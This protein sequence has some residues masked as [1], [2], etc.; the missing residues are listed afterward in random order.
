MGMKVIA[1]RAG[2]GKTEALLK[3]AKKRIE[4]GLKTVLIVPEQYSFQA[5]RDLI[6]RLEKPGILGT[7]VLSFSRLVYRV[8]ELEGGLG[9]SH[10][11]DLGKTMLLRK[12]FEENGDD[13]GVFKGAFKK[14]G[15]ITRLNRFLNELKKNGIVPEELLLAASEIKGLELL[16]EKLRDIA[17]AYEYMENSLE[18]KYTDTWNLYALAEEKLKN[19]DIYRETVFYVD[20]FAG[21]TGREKGLIKALLSKSENVV[22]TLTCSMDENGDSYVFSNTLR[23]LNELKALALEENAAFELSVFEPVKDLGELSFLRDHF[24]SYPTVVYKGKPGSVFLFA[25]KNRSSEIENAAGEILRLA[26]ENGC[27]YRDMVILCDMAIYGDEIRRV[28]ADYGIPCF[29]DQKRAI[30]GSAMARYLLSALET[31]E[32]NMRYEDVFAYLKTGLAD[33]DIETVEKL[34]NHVLARGIRGSLWK[35]PLDVENIEDGELLEAA[36]IKLWSRFDIFRSHISNAKN[37]RGYVESIYRFLD[38]GEAAKKMEEFVDKLTSVGDYEYASEYSQIWNILM[39]IFDQLIEVGGDEKVDLKTFIEILKSGIESY[40]V[41]IIPSTIDQVLV[42]GLKRTRFHRV[43]ALFMIGINDRVIPSVVEDSGIMLDE[44]IRIMQQKGLPVTMDGDT[45]V[46]EER[47]AIYNA[48]ARPTDFIWFSYALSDAEGQNLRPSIL[49]GRLKQLFPEMDEM[50]DNL[51]SRPERVFRAPKAAYGHV[52]EALRRYI[53]EHREMTDIEK[54]LACWISRSPALKADFETTRKA[55]F[56]DNMDWNITS[57]VASELYGAPLRSSSSRIERYYQCPFQHFVT[58]GLRPF[59]RKV[60]ELKSP[61]VGR[62]FHESVESFA[63]KIEDRGLDWR[64]LSKDKVDGIMSEAAKEIMEGFDGKILGSTER[65]KYFADRI[66]RVA[67]KTANMAVE[68]V[69]RGGFTPTA[70]EMAFG[71]GKPIPPIIIETGSGET[72][73]LEGRIDRIDIC[74]KD[75]NTYVKIIDYKSYDKPFKIGNAYYGIQIQLPIYLKAALRGIEASGKKATPAGAFYFK[76]DDPMVEDTGMDESQIE[77]AFRS[78]FKMRGV[79]LRDE[80]IIKLMDMDLEEGKSSDIIPARLKQDASPAKTV[81]SIE[82]EDFDNLLKFVLKAVGNAAESILEGKIDASP[83]RKGA[84]KACT[85][86]DFASICQFDK[87]L[88]GNTYRNLKSL[89][90]KEALQKME[91]D[92]QTKEE[93]GKE[94]GDDRG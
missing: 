7:E 57:K 11:S 18:E 68:H 36:R 90:D 13:F 80:R 56:H 5:E 71:E 20:G 70:S 27:R 40:E 72:I 22:F 43:K 54:T 15:F 49:A 77:S 66:E 23:T 87:D 3:L 84:D 61:D 47:F 83:F 91:S 30:T 48:I 8:L 14:Q 89:T 19:S 16:R 28:F 4:S 2:S 38:S 42:G 12:A 44:E 9:K 51:G 6:E 46:D 55:L 92:V 58:Y 59:E 50:G 32:R 64:E 45:R 67:K 33:M 35:K 74:E 37:I 24:Y 78:R 29:I 81:G 34:E 69:K 62:I 10:I 85:F 21:F 41:G 86:C 82:R 88:K 17:Y 79:V 26:E 53:E 25:A 63:K 76:I 93:N 73:R 94:G 52:V 65:Y 31:I 60:Y 75:E 39:E 1:G